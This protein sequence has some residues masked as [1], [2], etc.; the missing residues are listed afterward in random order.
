VAVI[1]VCFASPP[2]GARLERSSDRVPDKDAG[3]GSDELVN[4]Q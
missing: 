2:A 3:K 4:K 1:P